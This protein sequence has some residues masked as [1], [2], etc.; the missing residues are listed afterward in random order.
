MESEEEK[1]EG[2]YVEEISQEDFLD[3]NEQE[4]QM[5]IEEDKQETGEPLV[6][7]GKL[8]KLRFSFSGK[9]NFVHGIAVGLGLG[10]IGTF[11]IVWVSLFFVPQLPPEANYESLLAIFI[12]PL[13]YLLA[14]GLIALTAGIVRE[15][16]S[17]K[18]SEGIQ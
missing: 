18:P 16:Y 12:Y 7:T 2:A 3:D 15:Y 17:V 9:S 14:V 1:Q 4:E 10:C 11:I 6:K 13:I 8:P 5:V